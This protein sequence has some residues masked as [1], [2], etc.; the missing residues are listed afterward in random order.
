MKKYRLLKDLPNVKAGSPFEPT[1]ALAY[2]NISNGKWH[3]EYCNEIIE[4]NPEWFQLIEEEQP[5]WSDELVKEFWMGNTIHKTE[6]SLNLSIQKFKA[7]KTSSIPSGE[8]PKEMQ[9][10]AN[11][12]ERDLFEKISHPKTDRI[13]V[14]NIYCFAGEGS[15]HLQITVKTMDLSKEKITLIKQAIENILNQKSNTIDNTNNSFNVSNT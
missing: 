10:K 15:R 3:V 8:Y 12:W 5:F 14:G 9:E 2:G 11:Q 13:E 4:N 7:S 6:A 1:S